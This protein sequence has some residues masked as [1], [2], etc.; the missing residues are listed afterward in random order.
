M[1]GDG[2]AWSASLPS[3]TC[4]CSSWWCAGPTRSCASGGKIQASRRSPRTPGRT[5]HGR[6][7]AG[8]PPA[9]RRG[10]RARQPKASSITWPTTTPSLACPTGAATSS[11][12]PKARRGPTAQNP[13][14]GCGFIDPDQPGRERFP[15]HTIGDEL[16]FFQPP[17]F[18]GRSD[19]PT[20]W[21]VFGGDGSSAHGRRR[22]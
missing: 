5:A 15:R 7:E 1:V 4:C 2:P 19:D 9:R 8:Q 11:G 10:R 18:P 17:G 3:C 12:W 22:G 16:S 14:A 13:A 6:G 21:P 20:G